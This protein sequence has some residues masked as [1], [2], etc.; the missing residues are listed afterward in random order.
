MNYGVLSFEVLFPEE[1]VGGSSKE[2]GEL[3][4]SSLIYQ[5]MGS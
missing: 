4:S 1:D 5:Y 2:K 3:S